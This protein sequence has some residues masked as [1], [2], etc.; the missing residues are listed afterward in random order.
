MGQRGKTC[1]GAYQIDHT[2]NSN[3]LNITDK[4]NAHITVNGITTVGAWQLIDPPKSQ[5]VG[6]FSSCPIKLSSKIAKF[7]A[8]NPPSNL[9]RK[10]FDIAPAIVK[11][12]PWIISA[13][14]T[15]F[16]RGWG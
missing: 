15:H 7:E 10:Q 2:V 16:L 6:K 3:K 13:V 12:S 5:P 1:N 8:G 9:I 11:M 14:F 4:E